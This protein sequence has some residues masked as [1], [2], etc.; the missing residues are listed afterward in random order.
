MFTV[1]PI[2]IRL[3]TEML[4]TVPKDQAIYKTYITDP[5]PTGRRKPNS[6]NH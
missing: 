4:G 5:L 3:I 6:R 1:I 2:K